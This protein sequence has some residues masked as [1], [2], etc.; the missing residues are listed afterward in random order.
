M[1]AI[2]GRNC[3]AC[4]IKSVAVL[5]L[6]LLTGVVHAA[7]W[8]SYAHDNSRSAVTP[9]QVQFPLQQQWVYEAPVAPDPAWADP[10]DYAVEGVH[11]YNKT[12]FDD[13]FH[14][15][16]ADGAV[17]FATTTDDAVYCFDQKTGRERWHFMANGPVRLAPTIANGRVYFGSDDGYAYCLSAADGSVVW[18]VSGSPVQRRVLGHGHMIS[19]WPIRTGILV[20][21]DVAYF[22][23][24]IFPGERLYLRAVNAADGSPVW[25]ND[26]I[27][28]AGAGNYDLSPQGYLLASDEHLYVPSGRSLPAAFDK[29]TGKLSYKRSY[30]RWQTGAVAGTYASLGGSYALLYGDH[31]FVGSEFIAGYDQASGNLGFAWFPGRKLVVTAEVSY[32][33]DANGITALDRVKYP[34]LSRQRRDLGTRRA[35]IAKSKAKDKKEQLEAVDAQLKQVTEGIAACTAW[36]FEAE[37]LENMIVTGNAVIAG[38]ADIVIAIDRATGKELWQAPV[39]GLAK[40]LAVADGY[41]FVSTTTGNIHVFGPGNPPPAVEKQVITDPYPVDEMTP[42]FESTAKTIIEHS[43]VSRG[44][45]LVIGCGDGRLAYE[46]AKRSDLKVYGICMFADK[47][48]KAREKLRACGMLGSRIMVEHGGFAS[49][50]YSDYFANL[51]VSQQAIFAGK[52]TSPA[53][54]VLRVLKPCGGVLFIGQ[55]PNPPAKLEKETLDNWLA[56][57]E[58]SDAQRIDTNGSWAKYVRGPLPGAGSWTHQYGEPGNTASSTDTFLE[59]PLEVLWYGE[60]GPDKVPSRHAGNAAPLTINGKVFL[61]GINEIL[62]FDAYNGLMY[63]DRQIKGAYRTGMVR[64]CGNL[65]CDDKYLYLAAGAQCLQLDQETGDTLKTFDMPQVD[66]QKRSWRYVALTGGILFGSS[67]TKGQYSDTLFALDPATGKHLWVH[68]GKSIRNNAIAIS[69]GRIFFPDQTATDDDRKI[70]LKGKIQELMDTKNLSETDAVKEL[71]KVDVRK[72]FALDMRTGKPIWEVPVDLTGC[73]AHVLTAMAHDGVLVFCASHNNGHYWPQ[74]L[75]GEYASRAAVALSTSDG[76]LLWA[77]PLGYRIRPLI[78]EDK[79]IAEPWAFDLHTGEQITRTNPLTGLPSNWQFERPGHH[80]GNISGSPNGLWFRSWSFAYYDLLRDQGTEHFAG[81]RPGC[82]INMIPANGLLV[83]PE[84]SSGCV[85]LVS[86]HATT[87]FKPSKTHRAW[88]LFSDPGATLPVKTMRLNVGGPGDRADASGNLWLSYPRPRTTNRMKVKLSLGEKV[89]ADG[90][91][92]ERAAEDLETARTYD[93]WIY[94]SGLKGMTSCRIPLV[95]SGDGPAEYTL[96]L[97]F[98]ETDNVEPG[99]RVFDIKVQGKTLA[100]GF[101]IARSVG[102]SGKASVLQFTGIRVDDSMSLELVPKAADLPADEQPLVCGIEVVRERVLHVGMSAPDFTVSDLD[103]PQTGE[104]RLANYTDKTFEGTLTVAAPEMLGVKLDAL[105]VKLAPGQTTAVPVTITVAKK[106]AKQNLT[107]PWTLTWNDGKTETKQ[108]SSVE[109]LGARGRKTILPSE[110]TYVSAGGPT[111]NYGHGATILVD[112]GGATF[113]DESYNIGYLKFPID[114]PGK[115]VSATFRIHVP[116]GGHTQSA[117]SGRIKLVDND[118]D[119]YKINFDNRPKPGKELASLGKV[120]QD[121][122]VERTLNIDLSGM[123]ELSLVLD[124]TSNDGASYDSREAAAK[125][126]IIVEYEPEQ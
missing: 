93:P 77:K 22:A 3:G 1:S 31:L 89:M 40:G 17:Y 92:F 116:T 86:I 10:Q 108:E 57:G 25:T 87:V 67:S 114:I 44:Y 105:A 72:A 36:N 84:A 39:D 63:W 76:S 70:A 69:E 107:L 95:G 120:D 51:I 55:P 47:I 15:V 29:E 122:W 49:L 73:A 96:R 68:K 103:G 78:V 81:Q 34:E 5:S 104:I 20:E 60:P 79:L 64:E 109:Y 12:K 6:L 121:E 4:V 126:H 102:G 66:E 50:P 101:D 19:M 62:C 37:N 45:C 21:G 98:A 26:T 112:G 85:C 2:Q 48:Q 88:G 91:Y 30:S 14:V 106:G 41:V 18:R 75:G 52:I 32:M 53:E 58:M 100:K 94:A 71:A 56:S 119:E 43:G 115:P 28:D 111:T 42:F 13:V 59:C 35:N 83:A 74:F 61:E 7:G 118:W 123:K 16:A 82:W 9:E 80:C 24:G 38:G 46:I 54:E 99:K 90:G 8:P 124:P 117:D 27:S 33:L 125:P 97:H 23:A 110:D 11:E 65:A 113:G